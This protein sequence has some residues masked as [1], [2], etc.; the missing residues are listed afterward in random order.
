MN[1]DYPSLPYE[2]DNDLEFLRAHLE[3]KIAAHGEKGMVY[4]DDG[5]YLHAIKKELLKRREQ[6][7]A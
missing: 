3:E 2:S 7:K 1:D 5:H 6:R 4:E